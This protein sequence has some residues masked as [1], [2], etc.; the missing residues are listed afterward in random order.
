M[1]LKERLNRKPSLRFIQRVCDASEVH[2]VF[3]TPDWLETLWKLWAAKEAAY[4]AIV[5]R[6]PD[7]PFVHRDFKV[8]VET[9]T[10]QYREFL[11]HVRWQKY[12]HSIHCLAVF[13]DGEETLQWVKWKALRLRNWEMNP[14]EDSRRSRAIALDLLSDLTPGGERQDE[15]VEIKRITHPNR[16]SPPRF[17]RGTH[18]LEDFDLS[19]SHDGR[20][21]SAAVLK[22]DRNHVAC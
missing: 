3:S 12:K 11:I 1:D 20:Y 18:P 17:Y 8:D 7:T 22:Y 6:Y 5:K 10:V 14:G 13:G 19:L 4:K 21:I 2:C 16:Q 9:R 15:Q